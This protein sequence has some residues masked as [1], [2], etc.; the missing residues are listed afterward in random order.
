M[1]LSDLLE[2][3]RGLSDA[4]FLERF[5]FPFLLEEGRLRDEA[6]VEA[7]RQVYPLRGASLTVGRSSQN[8]VYV[9]DRLVSS[10]HALL[11]APG[12]GPGDRSSWRVSDAGSSNGTTVDDQPLKPG[13]VR[14]LADGSTLRLGA[15]ALSFL[16]P[17]SFLRLARRVSPAAPRDWRESTADGEERPSELGSMIVCC[18]SFA[19]A[20]LELGQRVVL[21]RD[22]QADLVLPSAKVSRRHAEIAR[23]RDGVTVRD[24]DSKNGTR[25]GGVPVGSAPIA[26]TLGTPVDVGPFRVRVALAS[27]EET[28]TLEGIVEPLTGSFLLQPPAE[29]LRNLE[30]CHLTGAL[31]VASWELTGT[32]AFHAGEPWDAWIDGSERGLPAIRRILSLREATFRFRSEPT[33][34][35]KPEVR[36]SV[37]EIL[38]IF[39]SPGAGTT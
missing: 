21:G 1:R 19:P 39:G 7:E 6:Q 5:R 37:S 15:H 2:C 32:V 36:W 35:R 17:T 3:V 23:G 9:E 4:A 11:L 28:T 29:L 30:R 18:E 38:R 10:R 34:A 12:A 22:P 25:V 20:P 14:G 27:R 16:T 31:E 33:G 26:L 24:L 8:D 13:E